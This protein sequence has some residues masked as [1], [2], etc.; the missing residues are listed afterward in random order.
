MT[1]A[2]EFINRWQRIAL[3]SQSL[4]EL[5]QRGEWD[6]LLEQEVTYLQ[7][8][9][10][11]METQTPPGITQSLQDM[12]AGYIKQTLDNEQLLRSLLQER[13]DELSNLIGQSA[14]QKS[15]NNAYG[16]LSGM[17]LVP[18]VPTAPQ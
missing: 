2:V 18:D 6:L 5:A 10:T 11:V 8:I 14:R 4:L 15:L 13:L 12:I 9:E 17:L 3:L 16:R 1:S 7:S